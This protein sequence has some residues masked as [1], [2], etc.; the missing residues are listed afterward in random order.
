MR[1]GYTLIPF[2][3]Q[4]QDQYVN[5]AYS[6]RNNQI[7]AQNSLNTCHLF[8]C[9]NTFVIYALSRT[10]WDELQQL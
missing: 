6:A 1:S 8:G 2:R 4:A 5:D 7:S 9:K 3:L 10:E